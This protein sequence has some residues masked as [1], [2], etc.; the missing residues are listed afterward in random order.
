MVK[1][2]QELTAENLVKLVE[3]LEVIKVTPERIKKH[4]TYMGDNN[5]GLVEF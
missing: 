1:E 4:K 3:A 5:G 2:T